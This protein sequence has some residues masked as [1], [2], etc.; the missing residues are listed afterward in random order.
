MNKVH[1][2]IIDSIEAI[3]SIMMES[4][5]NTLTELINTYSKAYTILENYEGNEVDSFTVFSEGYYMEADNESDDGEGQEKGSF[6][7]RIDEKTN[8]KESILKSIVWS[9]P[10]IF[11]LLWDKIVGIFKKATGKLT[12]RTDAAVKKIKSHD[13][14]V[15]EVAD[16]VT[17]EVMDEAFEKKDS[18]TS[19]PQET[20]SK[21]KKNKNKSHSIKTMDDEPPE[22]I[23]LKF[24]LGRYITNL[25]SKSDAQ[26][27]IMSYK[28][29]KAKNKTFTDFH[30][31]IEKVGWVGALASTA[32]FILA[33]HQDVRY[34][35]GESE[36]RLPKFLT[37][38]FIALTAISSIVSIVNRTQ[39]TI[40]YLG[41]R[42]GINQKRRSTLVCIKQLEREIEF[43]KKIDNSADSVINRCDTIFGT[44]NKSNKVSMGELSGL[45]DYIF[46]TFV[47]DKEVTITKD[48]YVDIITD[49]NLEKVKTLVEKYCTI[50]KTIPNAFSR[51]QKAIDK[52]CAL[53]AKKIS[54]DEETT[55]RIKTA[56]R[57]EGRQY[58]IEEKIV[59]LNQFGLIMS[60]MVEHMNSN[61]TLLVETLEAIGYACDEIK[62][63]EAS[64]TAYNK[65]SNGVNTKKN[66]EE[67]SDEDDEDEEES[68]NKKKKSKDDEDDE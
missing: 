55:S 36:T 45:I 51:L 47:D 23:K 21:A 37:P 60:G 52:T 66:K 59:F 9:I 56:K 19:S 44:K 68:S 12:N 64:P 13:A 27:E 53:A 17:A 25:V 3:D 42:H 15:V 58:S 32:G 41:Y 50:S 62:K 8:K 6:F 40:K 46:D 11:K 54:V 49:E 43:C 2:E 1:E 57:V 22:L 30:K 7:R 26:K 67:S 10:R 4:E 34:N 38:M 14:D 5:S 29:F 24:N 28:T 18:S 35:M 39:I 31:K 65:Q 16:S 20:K 63:I 48:D 61:V 33:N